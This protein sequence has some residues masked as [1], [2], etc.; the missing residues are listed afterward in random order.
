MPRHLRFC[1]EVFIKLQQIRINVYSSILTWTKVDIKR[2][3]A[4]DTNVVK[5]YTTLGS[6]VKE[7]IRSDNII[8]RIKN[9]T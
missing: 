3:K 9:A 6:G 8:D 1:S 5:E 7:I 2:L 4:V